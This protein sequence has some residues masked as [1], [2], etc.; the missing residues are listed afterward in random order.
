MVFNPKYL[1][2]E[3]I[4]KILTQLTDKEFEDARSRSLTPLKSTV[5]FK[6]EGSYVVDI[7]GKKYLDMTA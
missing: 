4:T 1:S 2:D 6:G 7:K 5:L 3:E